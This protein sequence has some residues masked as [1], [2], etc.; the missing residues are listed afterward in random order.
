MVRQ[1]NIVSELLER[2]DVLA[3]ELDELEQRTIP[4]R[5]VEAD[6]QLPHS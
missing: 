5:H 4:H 3:I 2:L 1:A 6:T